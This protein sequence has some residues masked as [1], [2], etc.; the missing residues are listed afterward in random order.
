MGLKRGK[1]PQEVT[2]EIVRANPSADEQTV[3][4]IA[5]SVWGVK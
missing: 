1:S 5:S 2:R 3:Y 4:D